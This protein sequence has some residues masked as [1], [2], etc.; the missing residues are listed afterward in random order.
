MCQ[1][2]GNGEFSIKTQAKAKKFRIFFSR[3]F[4]KVLD[5]P[6]SALSQILDSKKSFEIFRLFLCFYAGNTPIPAL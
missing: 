6:F 2:A 3:K 4:T 5:S 1:S